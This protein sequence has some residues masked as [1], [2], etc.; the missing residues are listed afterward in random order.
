[1][2]T[3]TGLTVRV[4]NNVVKKMDVKQRFHEAFRKDGYQATFQFKQ[5]VC[6]IYMLLVINRYILTGSMQ[7]DV[8]T[9]VCLL[10]SGGTKSEAAHLLAAVCVALLPL[11]AGEHHA[12]AQLML[13]A[14][15]LSCQGALRDV[16]FCSQVI[17]LFQKQDGV[18]VCIYC[19][20]MQ[21]YGDDCPAP[22]RKWVYLSYL[23]SVKYF[24]C[25]GASSQSP[26]CA[27]NPIALQGTLIDSTIHCH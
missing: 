1:M 25:R 26:V 12:L 16:G 13:E 20:Y 4:I 15:Q 7:T 19:L 6:H 5:K 9:G 14:T 8:C 23:D 11:R 27:D 3:A 10:S 22:N 17:M 2:P 21:E 24:R 18:D